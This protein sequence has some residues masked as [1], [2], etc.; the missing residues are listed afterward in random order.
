M[1]PSSCQAQVVALTGCCQEGVG[2]RD[3]RE[4]KSRL[5]PSKSHLRSPQHCSSS[6]TTGDL[7]ASGARPPKMCLRTFFL[8]SPNFSVS[9]ECIELDSSAAHPSTSL[10]T[11]F[12]II[13]GLI[14]ALYQSMQPSV[15]RLLF[16]TMPFPLHLLLFLSLPAGLG[17]PVWWRWCRSPGG[18]RRFEKGWS[19][20]QYL[21]SFSPS[22]HLLLLHR[23]RCESRGTLISD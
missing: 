10:A 16:S 17:D 19:G 4:W 12:P 1:R 8:L 21:T 15:S 14:M 5:L 11:R 23:R 22:F 20:S 7:C 9:P 2:N 3:V 18:C 6:D 13:K